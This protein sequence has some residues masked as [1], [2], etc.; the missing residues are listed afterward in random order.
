[1]ISSVANPYIA[2]ALRLRARARRARTGLVIV[3]GSRSLG[4]AVAAGAVSRVFHTTAGARRRSVLLLDA[5][6]AGAEVRE[7][8]GD[9]M[10]ALTS[11]AS[12]PDVLGVAALRFGDATLLRAD[13]F[14]ALL[15]S[16]VRDPGVAGTILAAAAGLGVR[17]V[18][19]GETTV[20]LGDP[21]VIRAA[22]G[23]HFALLVGR[24]ASD[25]EAV[26]KAHAVGAEVVAIRPDGPSIY[27]SALPDAMMLLVQ[28]EGTTMEDGA[29]V[30]VPSRAPLPLAAS[31][32]IV[33]HAWT[34]RRA[35]TGR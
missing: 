34:R 24:S 17:L 7:V 2:S 30:S 1:M 18:L 23:A 29:G 35:P 9:V 33:L 26:A 5:R 8:S 31:A 14:P 10:A 6:A 32:A 22:A 4:A 16:A 27:D 15:L 3:E 28:G 12:T 19:Q 25:A 11:T 13:A 21:R 20:D